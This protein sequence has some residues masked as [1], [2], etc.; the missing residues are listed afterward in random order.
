MPVARGRADRIQE[1]VCGNYTVRGKSGPMKLRVDA[2][3]GLAE[4]LEGETMK[5]LLARA[6]SEMYK[7]KSASRVSSD[8]SSQ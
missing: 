1:W 2:S 7:N 5:E 3:F 4:H 8:Q 6:D